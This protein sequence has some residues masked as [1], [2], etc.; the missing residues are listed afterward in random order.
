[1]WVGG[2]AGTEAEGKYGE[3]ESGASSKGP[4]RDENVGRDG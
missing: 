4:R 2:S 1:V 3:V